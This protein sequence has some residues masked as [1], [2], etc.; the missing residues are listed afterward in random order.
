MCINLHVKYI[1]SCQF[2]MKLQFP[3]QIFRK[4]LRTNE[5]PSS[6]RRVVPCRGT[7][8]LTDITKLIVAFRNFENASKNHS[9]GLSP[10]V[11]KAKLDCGYLCMFTA[12]NFSN[13][14]FR[15]TV[16]VNPIPVITSC[17][18]RLN[19]QTFYIPSTKR[20][21]VFCMYLRTREII[22]LHSN[23][24]SALTKKKGSVYCTVRAD[25]INEIVLISVF[26]G[27]VMT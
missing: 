13:G 8:G 24:C 12:T 5:N 15:V 17:T 27:F 25:S 22:F 1:F 19:M 9:Y 23:K 14:G 4:I 11:Y 16:Y 6:G 20:N 21:F 3:R 10:F 26:E 7:D 2:S 18:T